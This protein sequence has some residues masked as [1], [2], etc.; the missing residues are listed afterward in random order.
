MA[1]STHLAQLSPKPQ[2]ANLQVPLPQAPPQQP[3]PAPNIAQGVN[4][5][6]FYLYG[7]FSSQTTN[8]TVSTDK[9]PL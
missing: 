6:R 1:N 5:Y 3:V 8:K 7:S 4:I 2:V 9:L